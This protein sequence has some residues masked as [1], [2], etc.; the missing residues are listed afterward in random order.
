MKSQVESQ[1]ACCSDLVT[2]NLEVISS[3]GTREEDDECDDSAAANDTEPVFS[4]ALDVLPTLLFPVA[5]SDNRTALSSIKKKKRTTVNEVRRTCKGVCIGTLN[6]LSADAFVVNPV[7]K[8]EIDRCPQFI[9]RINRGPKV[10]C[11]VIIRNNE[12]YLPSME[13]E[14]IDKL[15]LMWQAVDMDDYHIKASGLKVNKNIFSVSLY[16]IFRHQAHKQ[17]IQIRRNACD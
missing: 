15:I 9:G 17:F 16:L 1:S 7:C 11:Y 13:I 3:P 2:R 12:E 10:P 6:H 8:A 14:Y 4:S 5:T